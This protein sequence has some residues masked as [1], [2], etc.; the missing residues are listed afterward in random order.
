MT[1]TLGRVATEQ[2]A[3]F[4][5]E[6]RQ[7]QHILVTGNTGSGKTTLARKI[8]QE[9]IRRGGFVVVFVGKLG[10]DDTITRDYSL[11]DGWTRWTKWHSSPKVFEN[12][13][14][15]WP[16]TDKFK[17]VEDAV[18]H[19]SEVFRDAFNRLIRAG[20]WTVQI[21]EGL[22]TTSPR[23]LKLGRHLALSQQQ[24]RSANL[25]VMT[26]AQRPSNLPLEVYGSATHAF[27]ARCNLQEDR[28]RL[29]QL[30]LSDPKRTMND[31]AK[32][33]PHEFLW[34]PTRVGSE[35]EILDLSR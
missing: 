19:Q 11:R 30:G 35:A 9:R 21:D 31:I 14:L 10:K 28:Q 29:A 32:L 18:A 3:R 17:D 7:G 26:L 22:Y 27:T 20:H 23:F 8:L 15:L 1:P 5:R 33:G 24:G 12:K 6:W 4:G 2:L 25:S 16:N 13:V 34:T